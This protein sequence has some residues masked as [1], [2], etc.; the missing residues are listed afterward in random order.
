MA[1][2][3]LT[4]ETLE[5]LCYLE[6]AGGPV[7]KAD[8]FERFKHLEDSNN[9]YALEQGI[10]GLVHTEFV[11]KEVSPAPN[12]MSAEKVSYELSCQG[13]DFLIEALEGAAD[14]FMEF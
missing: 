14:L 6:N 8:L 5:I 9:P 3:A 13:R 4:T 12:Y 1:T 7:N 2:V 10:E 11:I